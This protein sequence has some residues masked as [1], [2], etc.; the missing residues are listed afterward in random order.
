[1]RPVLLIAALMLLVGCGQPQSNA[2]SEGRASPS[3]AATPTPDVALR[4]MD[5]V[6]N[7]TGVVRRVDRI[8][9][10]QEKWGDILTRSGSQIPGANPNE[11]VWVVAVVG[12]VAPS[13]GLARA[14]SGAYQCAA[15][16]FDGQENGKSSAYGALSDCARYFS[17]SLVPPSAPV[18]CPREPQ[19]YAYDGHGPTTK[20]PVTL[21]TSRDD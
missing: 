20:G 9:A 5:R 13:F 21:T 17:D 15:F 6:R 12:D 7:M 18:A 1:M 3:P 19:G 14:S 8:A 16:V 11:D 4:L 2:L 10:A